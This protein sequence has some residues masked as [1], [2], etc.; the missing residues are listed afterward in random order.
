MAE[1]KGPKMLSG[2]FSPQF[3]TRLMLK[4]LKLARGLAE[5]FELPVPALSAVKELFQVA[6]NDGY[7]DEDMSAIVKCYEDWG[8]AGVSHRS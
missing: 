8:K 1:M 5:S 3:M 4:D 6:C 7:G 2:D